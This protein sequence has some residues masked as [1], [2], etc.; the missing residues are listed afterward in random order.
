MNIIQ[1]S[2]ILGA[3]GAAIIIL[4]YLIALS[5]IE[6]SINIPAMVAP[7]SS[8]VKVSA[9]KTVAKQDVGNLV[10]CDSFACLSD[11][12]GTC[13]E[14]SI[15]QVALKENLPNM[16]DPGSEAEGGEAKN[17][18]IDYKAIFKVNGLNDLGQCV[19]AQVLF[20]SRAGVEGGTTD[21]SPE[22][23]VLQLLDFFMSS[24]AGASA[25]CSGQGSDISA[26]FHDMIFDIETGGEKMEF[27]ETET[28]SKVVYDN[29]VTCLSG[30]YHGF[31]IINHNVGLEEK[32]LLVNTPNR[33]LKELVEM[34]GAECM[35]V[36]CL[37][38]AIAACEPVESVINYTRFLPLGVAS[39]DILSQLKVVGTNESGLCKIQEKVLQYNVF[40]DQ[41]EK[42]L[43]QSLRSGSTA[44]VMAKDLLAEL[45]EAAL[46][47]S[48][49]PL[50]STN[51]IVEYSGSS[52]DLLAYFK[53]LITKESAHPSLPAPNGDLASILDYNISVSAV[54]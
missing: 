2:L 31:V 35:S 48:R 13:R 16:A 14:N 44:S 5:E 39:F 53:G 38:A 28:G 24:T 50:D 47:Q 43:I 51:E 21:N 36:D 3:Q 19:V 7:T 40:I 45:E 42:D 46:L 9:E 32:L 10:F 17:F 37:E 30:P 41:K 34:S 54:Y 6:L 4:A 15:I 29:K 12:L 27:I 1:K 20:D 11:N 18:T 33:P 22:S 49:T 52:E 25:V 8:V 26:Y 23:K